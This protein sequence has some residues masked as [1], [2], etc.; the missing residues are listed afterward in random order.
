MSDALHPADMVATTVLAA[1]RPLVLY[2]ERVRLRELVA[3]EPW[4][5]VSYTA[6][7]PVAR[8]VVLVPGRLAARLLDALGACGTSV[9]S[10]RT[11]LYRLRR[12]YC[13]HEVVAATREEEAAQG[14][15]P[16]GAQG[17]AGGAG[18]EPQGAGQEATR[19]SLR[20]LASFTAAYLVKEC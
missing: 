20:G 17:Q 3:A 5:L 18:P 2:A 15:P 14:A 1:R 9:A 12:L 13:G 19:G 8:G 10:S 7:T 6:E 4:L 11:V 16:P